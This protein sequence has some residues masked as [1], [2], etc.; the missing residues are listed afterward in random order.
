MLDKTFIESV[1]K[2]HFRTDSDTGAHPSALFIW[3]MVREHAGMPRL[4]KSD[5]PSWCETHE[6]YHVIQEGYGCKRIREDLPEIKAIDWQQTC[7]SETKPGNRGVIVR[8]K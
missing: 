5:L 3:N 2:A 8:A 4:L 6:K 7:Y 1:E